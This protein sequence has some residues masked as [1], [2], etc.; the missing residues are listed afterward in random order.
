[1][2]QC[3]CTSLIT[4]SR[5]NGRRRHILLDGWYARLGWPCTCRWLYDTFSTRGNTSHSAALIGAYASVEAEEWREMSVQSPE[6]KNRTRVTLLNILAVAR[7]GSHSQSVLSTRMFSR[8]FVSNSC[9]A[10]DK[11][12]FLKLP[13][14]ER[15]FKGNVPTGLL[16]S[17]T[18]FTDNVGPIRDGPCT[19]TITIRGHMS[20]HTESFRRYTNDFK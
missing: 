18:M 20:I 15:S 14:Q 9:V 4:V 5:W 7:W 10:S 3:C 8:L 12:T 19:F 17:L 16:L 6:V 13:L 2:Q 1:M 11:T